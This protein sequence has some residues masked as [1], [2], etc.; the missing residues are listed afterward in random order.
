[1]LWPANIPN[2]P[3]TSSTGSKP[4]PIIGIK[5]RPLSS[6]VAEGLHDGCAVDNDAMPS[7]VLVLALAAQSAEQLLG[8]GNNHAK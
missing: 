4:W 3:L 1:M 2:P 6:G 8:N 7:A 5:N